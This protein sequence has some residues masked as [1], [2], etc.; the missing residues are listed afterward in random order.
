[1]PRWIVFVEYGLG[2]V[3]LLWVVLVVA[4]S[5]KE[6]RARLKSMR[7]EADALKDFRQEKEE[8]HRNGNGKVA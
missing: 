3:S 7:L 1:M 2:A 8:N 6:M 5:I 4:F